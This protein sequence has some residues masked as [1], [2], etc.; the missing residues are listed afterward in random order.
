MLYGIENKMYQGKSFLWSGYCYIPAN[1]KL[2]R[3]SDSSDY[4]RCFKVT[5]A[6]FNVD[7]IGTNARVEAVLS[8]ATEHCPKTI[9]MFALTVDDFYENL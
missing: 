5:K 1:G 7:I 6:L 2:L 9:C 3:I 8:I 4:S